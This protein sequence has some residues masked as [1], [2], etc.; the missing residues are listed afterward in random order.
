MTFV[1]TGRYL[2][3]TYSYWFTNLSYW[4][5]CRHQRKFKWK[6]CHL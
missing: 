6:V 3:G 4:L 2:E 1:K 5:A